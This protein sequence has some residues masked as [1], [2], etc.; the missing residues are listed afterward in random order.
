MII[1]RRRFKQATNL[2][3]RLAEAAK[4]A[5]EQAEQL[6]AGSKRESLLQKA[7]ED[8]AAADMTAWLSPTAHTARRARS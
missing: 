6:P 5:R 3:E 1:R 7:R 2:E 4:N 8:Q